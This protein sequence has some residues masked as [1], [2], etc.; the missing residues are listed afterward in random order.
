MLSMVA[1]MRFVARGTA[2]LRMPL[3]EGRRLPSLA[4]FASR[5]LT[6][7]TVTFS[8][9][10][11]SSLGRYKVIRTFGWY[12]VK[13]ALQAYK[14]EYGDLLVPYR[15][16]VPAAE[17][18]PRAMWGEGLGRVANNIRS[19]GAYGGHYVELEAMGF[20]Y[21]P[22]AT[23]AFGWYIVKEA[24]QAYKTEYGDLL[25]PQ[26]FV[27]PAAEPWP[28]AMWGKGFGWV[29]NDIRNKGAYGGHRAELEAM[30]FDFSKQAKAFGWD[31][32]KEAL[33][34]Y[35]FEYGDL[36]VLARFVVPAAEPWPRAMWGEG[37]GHVAKDIRNKG[38]YG[39]HRAELE[40]MGFDFSKQLTGS[41]FGWDV[42]KEALQAYKTEYGDLL[43]PQLF[44]V[45]AAEQWPRAMWGKGFGR[46]AKD[47]RNKG[48]YGEHR[49]ELEAMGF[50]YSQ[51]RKDRGTRNTYSTGDVI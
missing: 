47:I 14:T 10:H 26:R 50:D 20:D 6:I 19:N 18:W 9:L 45:P 40:A 30:G 11:V 44:V 33:Q 13:E 48:T 36:L 38:T 34:A 12:W 35:K 23:L 1:K 32:V 41:A 39:G 21:S 43:V 42:V 27:V 8:R 25:V 15:F 37:L 22:Q 46:V 51:R 28:R 17:P 49:A 16:V 2:W 31:V 7:K 29:A 5:A 3:G 4:S 24:F